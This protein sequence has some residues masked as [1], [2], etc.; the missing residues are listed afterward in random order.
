MTVRS[1]FVLAAALLA[2]CGTSALVP[3]PAARG[4]NPAVAQAKLPGARETGTHLEVGTT[5]PALTMTRLDT[6]ED[7]L[8]NYRG[9]AVL[10]AFWATWCPT[11]TNELPA[12]EALHV[13]LAPQGLNVLCVNASNEKLK[14]LQDLW[15][16]Q[17][18]TMPVFGQFTGAATRDFKVSN[19]PT[20]YWVTKAGVIQ[21]WHVGE[22]DPADLR[23]RT[24]KLLATP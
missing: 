16:W 3:R 7:R 18:Y 8:E 12:L 13:D 11:C 5:V 10:L 24:A 1:T 20:L 17:S 21:D 22:M 4:V 23:A 9:K 15:T 14:K 6:Q 2:G 19:I